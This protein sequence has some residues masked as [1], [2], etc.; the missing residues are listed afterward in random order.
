M[1][2]GKFRWVVKHVRKATAQQSDY[3]PQG[4]ILQ[5]PFK[6]LFDVLY[7]AMYHKFPSFDVSDMALDGSKVVAAYDAL[8]KDK[9]LSPDGT[10]NGKYD[11]TGLINASKEA[12]NKMYP[13]QEPFSMRDAKRTVYLT[14]MLRHILYREVFRL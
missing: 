14:Y 1:N 6:P 5:Q 3:K 12:F 2:I 11:E 9:V 4:E 7:F 8:V 13:Q 10:D